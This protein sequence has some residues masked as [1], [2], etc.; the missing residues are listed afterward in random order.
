MKRF[1]SP[2]QRY[3]ADGETIA[4][5]FL[6]S[7]GFAIVARNVSGSYGE[8][9]IIGKKEGIYYFFEVKT[10]KESA[11]INPAENLTYHKIRKVLRTAEYY[12]MIHRIRDY[13]VEGMIVLIG[14]KGE[15]GVERLDII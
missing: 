9:D 8:I 1:T 4:C 6:Q 3:G 12:C 10:G 7:E 15:V 14:P 5:E 13:R 11:G 2:S